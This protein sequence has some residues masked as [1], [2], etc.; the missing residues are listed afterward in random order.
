MEAA[1]YAKE[2]PQNNKKTKGKSPTKTP[3]LLQ[4]P[5]S[6]PFIFLRPCMLSFLQI[7]FSGAGPL[8]QICLC[9]GYLK[10]ADLYL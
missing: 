10:A 1:T 4:T 7:N 9:S 2:A 8:R 3:H 5:L 6:F